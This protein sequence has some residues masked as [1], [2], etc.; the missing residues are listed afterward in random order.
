MAN[1]KYGLV[2]A[3]HLLI[4][5][6]D[7]CFNTASVLFFEQSTVQL[8]LFILQDTLIVMA[9]I[10]M[11][12]MFSSTFIFQAGLISVLLKRFAATIVFERALGAEKHYSWPTYITVMYTTQR[13][14]AILYYFMYK[15]T[16]LLLSNPKFHKDSEWLREKIRQ[17]G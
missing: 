7:L 9:I 10:V 17:G 13:I 11:A 15:R 2:L 14:V 1:N 4:I 12:I 5:F 6:L 8:M 3:L 16:I